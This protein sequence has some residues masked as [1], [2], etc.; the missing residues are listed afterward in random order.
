[1]SGELFRQD[2]KSKGERAVVQGKDESKL[3][4]KSLMALV[5]EEPKSND[6]RSVIDVDSYNDRFERAEPG[7]PI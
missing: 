3:N 6:M 2:G 1:M 7:E 4:R 5:S